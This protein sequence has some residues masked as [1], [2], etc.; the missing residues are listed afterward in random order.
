[1][2]RHE[3]IGKGHIREEGFQVILANRII[4]KLPGILETPVDKP[5]DDVRNLETIRRLAG[6]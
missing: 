4:R 1:M 2:D 5:G 6:K 3:H